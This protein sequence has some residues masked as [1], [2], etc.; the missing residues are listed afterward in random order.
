M[1]KLI[2]LVLVLAFI[3]SIG[4]G[5]FADDSK[6][7]EVSEETLSPEE[8]YEKAAELYYVDYKYDE[9]YE[10][11][12]DA[13]KT[14]Y[15]PLIRLLAICY[16]G[17]FGTDVNKEETFRLL[18]LAS[19]AGDIISNYQIAI[20]Y[21]R[22]DITEADPDKAQLIYADIFDAVN[23]EYE[24]GTDKFTKGYLANIIGC[25]YAFGDGGIQI[26]R[27]KAYDYF[28][29]S[30][31]AGYPLGMYNLGT[32]YCTGDVVEIDF[33][34][35]KGLYEKAAELGETNSLYCIGQLYY[36]GNGVAMDKATAREWF[37]KGA[38]KNND[39]CKQ[40]LDEL[41]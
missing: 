15:A 7:N 31:D 29:L 16:G 30:S 35:A 37:E 23:K 27:K 12:K 34:K 39:F 13:E 18:N 10:L 9:I 8:L 17:G 20:A 19:D 28:K 36:Y 6:K 3:F 21:E 26:D 25:Y 41:F 24:N 4:I 32:Y 22:G 5:A 40:A 33:I 38:E 2:C 11:V 14:G 1:K